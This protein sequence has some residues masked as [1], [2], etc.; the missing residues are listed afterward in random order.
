MVFELTQRFLHGPLELWIMPGNHLFGPIL[1]LYVWR[2][3]FIL[4]CPFAV[5]REEAPSRSNH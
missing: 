1:D 2:H 5:A 3:A 4:N